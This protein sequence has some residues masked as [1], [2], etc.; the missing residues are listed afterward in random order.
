MAE[1]AIFRTLS[2]S[3][4]VDLEVAI[5]AVSAFSIAVA[6][7]TVFNFAIG[8]KLKSGKINLGGEEVLTRDGCTIVRTNKVRNR[9]L[10]PYLRLR[11]NSM[12]CFVVFLIFISTL[13]RSTLYCKLKAL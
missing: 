1:F 8:L 4:R 11:L 12:F 7:I 3:H 10:W 2:T 6:F 5:F 9:S 13:D